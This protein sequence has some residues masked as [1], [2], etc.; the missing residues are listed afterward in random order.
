MPITWPLNEWQKAACRTYGDG[1]FAIYA[2]D[3]VHAN[4]A[5]L[6]LANRLGD[7]TFYSVMVELDESEGCTAEDAARRVS[8]I[9]EDLIPVRAALL[10]MS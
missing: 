9:M 1:D 7:S 2:S 3:N 6:L 5:A 4:D 10:L 8:Q